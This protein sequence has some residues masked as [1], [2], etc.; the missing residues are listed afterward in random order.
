MVDH[1]T[2][3][4]C[5]ANGFD[6]TGIKELKEITAL[7]SEGRTLRRRDISISQDFLEPEADLISQAD[8]DFGF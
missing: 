6:W 5:I 7:V 4:D 3:A 1:Q 8:G 2:L